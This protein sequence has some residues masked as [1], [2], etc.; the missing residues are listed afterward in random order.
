[1][2]TYLT[3]GNSALFEVGYG[4]LNEDEQYSIQKKILFAGARLAEE[5]RAKVA[6]FGLST[7]DDAYRDCVRVHNLDN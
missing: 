5:W 7:L 4:E 6:A 3:R 2:M 1:M